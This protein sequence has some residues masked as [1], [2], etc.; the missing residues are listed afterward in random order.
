[1]THS[2]WSEKMKTM[3]GKY[4]FTDPEIGEGELRF[5]GTR[6]T[7]ADALYLMRKA[8]TPEDVAF[9]FDH[10]ITK[11]AVEEAAELAEQALQKRHE[12]LGRKHRR[13]VGE[14]T[15]MRLTK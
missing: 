6:I 2:T 4:I 1:M 13:R 10:C 11:E 5:L 8:Y 15:I 14:A 12:P 9:Q 3:L 7:V